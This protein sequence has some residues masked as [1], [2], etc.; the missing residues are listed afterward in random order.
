MGRKTRRRYHPV[1]IDHSEAPEAQVTRIMV[2]AEREGTT[3]I[4]PIEFSM[5]ALAASPQGDHF[6]CL[7]SFTCEMHPGLIVAKTPQRLLQRAR[8]LNVSRAFL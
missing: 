3:A 2:V 1:F 4:E 6:R 7:S 5:S 8:V